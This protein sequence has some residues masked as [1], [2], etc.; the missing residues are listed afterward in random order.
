MIEL[1]FGCYCSELNIHPKNWQVNKATIKQEWYAFYRFYDPVFKENPKYK[2]GKLII[3]KGMNHF[4]GF[5]ERISQAKEIIAKELERLKNDGYNPITGNSIES[6]LN[7]VS[8]AATQLSYAELPRI[9][10][11]VRFDNS[12]FLYTILFV[13]CIFAEDFL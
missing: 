9:S 8:I 12:G 1:P 3:L 6:I 13:L 10:S 11:I 5:E 2:K 4:K 7:L